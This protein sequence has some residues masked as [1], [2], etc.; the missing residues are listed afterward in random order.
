MHNDPDPLDPLLEKWRNAAPEQPE[1]VAPEVW[2]RLAHVETP[3][4]APELWWQQ[5]LTAFGR[6]AFAAAFVA[7]CVV[8]GLFLAEVRLSRIQAERSERLERSYLELIDPLLKAEDAPT[9]RA[10]N[11]VLRQ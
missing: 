8:S 10:Q 4:A 5:L 11:A 9:I 6:P 3:A 7:V 2:R 1:S